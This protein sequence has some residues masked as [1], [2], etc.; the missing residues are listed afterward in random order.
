MRAL[1]YH[2]SNDV[3]VDNMPDPIIQE[4][5]DIILRVTATAI[6]GSDLHLYRG[7]IPETKDGDIFGHEFMGVVEE[8]GSGVTAVAKG[9]RVVVPFVIACGSCFFCAM[10]LQAACETT[11]TGRGA[12]LNKKQIP[13]GA[14]LFGFSHLYGGIPGGQAE[15]VR[16]PKA[17]VGPFKIPDSIDDERVLFL[18]DILPTGYQAVLNAGIGHGSSLVIHGAGPVG[19]MSAACAR[20]LG[21]QQI[22]MV[23]HHQYRLDFAVQHYGVIP[24]NFDEI[25][26]PAAAIIEQ[27]AGYR[28]VDA[29]IDAVGFEAKGSTL[30]TAL[31]ALKMEGSSGAALRQC[32]AA[33]RRGG[34]ISVPGVYA[35]FI[36]GF[37]F[38]DVFEKG[39]SFK[40]GQTHVQSYLPTLIEY[41]L[42]GDL[43][44]E[45]IISH[46]LSLEQA[47]EGY[48]I[49]DKKEDACRKIILRP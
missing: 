31:T 2:G 13:A 35:G 19:L 20:L 46:R 28:G 10:N 21:A 11:N 44:P 7:K 9:D 32:I 4:S 38:G 33:V 26:D 47:A 48:R 39:L 3:R 12:I 45:I 23:D 42:Q 27:T 34:T 37:M 5:D 16:V 1:T 14:A 22:F 36:H 25:D 8:V 24:I 29:A 43:R 49:F 30:E 41:I 40:T 18:S 6:C 15:F 17:N